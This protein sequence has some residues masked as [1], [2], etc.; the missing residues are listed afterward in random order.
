MGTK[1]LGT[2]SA[3]YNDGDEVDAV[4]LTCVNE[5]DALSPLISE[6]RG[7]EAEMTMPSVVRRLSIIMSTDTNAVECA[8]SSDPLGSR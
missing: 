3:E 1:E 2:Y 4:M 7:C 6:V 5:I 8:W